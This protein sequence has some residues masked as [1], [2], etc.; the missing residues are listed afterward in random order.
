MALEPYWALPQAYIWAAGSVLHHTVHRVAQPLYAELH[1]YQTNYSLCHVQAHTQHVCQHCCNQQEHDLITRV[2]PAL[3]C[4]EACSV[5]HRDLDKQEAEIKEKLKQEKK[6][7]ERKNREAFSD[8]LREDL[9]EGF[10]KPKMRWRVRRFRTSFNNTWVD[11]ILPIVD[12]SETSYSTPPWYYTAG[13]CWCIKRNFMQL[14]SVAVV[15]SQPGCLPAAMLRS[16]NQ[17]SVQ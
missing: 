4:S 2:Q 14:H 8:L 12:C 6:R 1:G 3:I 16:Y 17:P 15:G 5:Y 7:E 11:S 13:S 9:D 10:I